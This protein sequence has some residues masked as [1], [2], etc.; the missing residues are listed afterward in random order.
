MLSPMMVTSKQT[1]LFCSDSEVMVMFLSIGTKSDSSTSVCVCVCGCGCGCGC[2]I[3]LFHN[4]KITD[5]L[6][7]ILIQLLCPLYISEVQ[8]V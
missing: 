3:N 4:S 2:V 6:G 5:T 1:L 8:N 7:I